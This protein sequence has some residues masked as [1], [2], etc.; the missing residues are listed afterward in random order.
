MIG[1]R[2]PDYVH[3]QGQIVF[4]SVESGDDARWETRDLRPTGHG[5]SHFVEYAI[6]NKSRV[7]QRRFRKSIADRCSRLQAEACFRRATLDD[8]ASLRFCPVKKPFAQVTR[9]KVGG[10]H[11]S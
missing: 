1:K 3:E 10:A 6:R 4:M 7:R 11:P 8:L 9:L 5:N 2:V